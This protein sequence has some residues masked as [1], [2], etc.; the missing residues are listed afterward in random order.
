MVLHFLVFRFSVGP[1]NMKD[2]Q[3]LLEKLTD[4][5]I[6]PNSKTER[7]RWS[8]TGEAKAHADRAHPFVAATPGRSQP[9]LVAG[10]IDLRSRVLI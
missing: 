3:A 2:S 4:T 10:R 8:L 7:Q 1:C 5:R 9:S 6:I